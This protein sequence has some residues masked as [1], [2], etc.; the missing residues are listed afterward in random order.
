MIES[1]TFFILGS[2]L[3]WLVLR[4]YY[5]LGDKQTPSWFSLEKIKDILTKNPENIDWTAKQ[6][7]NLYNN[8]ISDDSCPVGYK[9]C[10]RC[11]SDNLDGD[12]FN[13]YDADEIYYILSCRD[14]GWSDCTQ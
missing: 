6:I 4:Y 11:G 7:V 8:K 14:C 10:P 12:T 3:S 13:D 9:F 2:S 1:I 5:K